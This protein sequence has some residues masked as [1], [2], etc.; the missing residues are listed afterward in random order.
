MMELVLLNPL[1]VIT[2][3][4]S[5]FEVLCPGAGYQQSLGKI[6]KSEEFGV[7]V[8]AVYHPSPLNLADR[9]RRLEFEH[10]IAVLAGL[11]KR[12]SNPDPE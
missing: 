5:A 9:G 4:A 1:L 8:Y 3:G 11:I 2:L 7:K 12:L 6:T 10:Q